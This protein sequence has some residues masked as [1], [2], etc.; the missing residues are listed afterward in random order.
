VR[1]IRVQTVVQLV[2]S[3]ALPVPARDPGE[4][5]SLEL[6]DPS[7]KVLGRLRA[8]GAAP[9]VEITQPAGG[10]TFDGEDVEV[11]WEASD[12]N[13]DPLR[14]LVQFRAGA[15]APWKPVAIPVRGEAATIPFENLP[16]GR[17]AAF[18]VLVSDGL[19]TTVAETAL[20]FTVANRP[21]DVE[22]DSPRAGDVVLGAVEA[23]ADDEPTIVS[24]PL[25]L[26]AFAH[27]AD[28][29]VL[30]GDALSWT[31][32]VDGPLGAGARLAVT[33]LTP[34]EHVIAVEAD[35]G[36]GAVAHADVSITV[37][38][39]VDE[40]PQPEGLV[41][42]PG[43]LGL[44]AHGG[45]DRAPLTI[46]EAGLRVVRWQ[47]S[48]NR[49]WL[50]LGTTAG[51]TPARVAVSLRPALLPRGAPRAARWSSRAR[52]YRTHVPSCGWTSRSSAEPGRW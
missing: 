9:S 41:V 13:G 46:A 21:P 25:V 18:R 16:S 36:K 26:E 3:A 23:E 51:S 34:G 42:E 28:A 48:A 29:G 32:D 33:E 11:R 38:G 50:R 22:I 39:A 8:G 37:A 24:Q 35:D 44:A 4:L 10:E 1:G 45:R 7:G 17:D 43:S 15:G 19:H 27:D 47:A 40:L 52:I 30:E 20:P 5:R 49:P 2:F 31:S 6:R 14:T 12:P